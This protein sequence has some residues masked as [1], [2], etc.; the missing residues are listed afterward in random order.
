MPSIQKKADQGMVRFYRVTGTTLTFP[1]LNALII[2]LFIG[3]VLLSIVF[4][5]SLSRL[6]DDWAFFLT[7]ILFGGVNFMWTFVL[8]QYIKI[9]N[10]IDFEFMT[11]EH[12]E[13][14]FKS[15]W[16]R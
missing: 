14:Y 16:K 4:L 5:Y 3:C 1:T 10:K 8:M 2:I 12:S 11:V 13:K 7:I 9:N 6:M 15:I